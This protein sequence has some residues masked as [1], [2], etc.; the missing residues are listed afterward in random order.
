MLEQPLASAVNTTTTVDRTNNGA[1]LVIGIQGDLGE[2]WGIANQLGNGAR[3]NPCEEEDA[4]C[5]SKACPRCRRRG[6]SSIEAPVSRASFAPTEI[7]SPQVLCRT[8]YFFTD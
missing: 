7:P 4:C 5:G 8:D 2:E 1:G 3:H 6:L